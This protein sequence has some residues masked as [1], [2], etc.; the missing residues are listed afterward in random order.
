SR[1]G[2]YPAKRFFDELMRKYFGEY[3]FVKQLT[4]PEVNIFEMTQVYV[5]QFQNRQVD[6][7]IPQAGLIFEIDG[8]QH[9][10]SVDDKGRDEFTQTLGLKTIRFTTE[11]IATENQSFI[12][13]MS[14]AVDHMRMIDRLEQE[15]ILSPPNG[16]TLRDYRL[17][18][19][20]GVD[21]GSPSIRLTAAIRFQLLVLEL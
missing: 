3:Q 8:K 20:E 11:E 5:D 4:L 15:G 10:A 16:L 14:S 13:K 2:N 17:A 19:N 18:Y 1:T 21:I 7:F 9:E 6:F 12:G